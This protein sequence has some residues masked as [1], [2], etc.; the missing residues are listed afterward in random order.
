MTFK[1]I[2]FI[3]HSEAKT[4]DHNESSTIAVEDVSRG[5]SEIKELSIVIYYIPW[6]TCDTRY[7]VADLYKAIFGLPRMNVRGLIGLR[8]GLIGDYDPNDRPLSDVNPNLVIPEAMDAIRATFAFRIMMGMRSNN[9]STIV[10]RNRIPLSKRD[11]FWSYEKLCYG[12][13]AKVSDVAYKRWFSDY[14][15]PM[16][17]VR[18]FPIWR[19][20]NDEDRLEMFSIISD[21]LYK[22]AETY[23][24]IL[25]YNYATKMIRNALN[26]H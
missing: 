7:I 8:N 10:I 17:Y 6:T 21:S 22:I 12:G 19:N 11:V 15:D 24:C 16:S 5:K 4:Y 9:E 20:M 1:F 3:H 14:S 26:N 2:R 23:D 25:L 18:Q 13:K